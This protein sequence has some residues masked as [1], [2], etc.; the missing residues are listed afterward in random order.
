MKR[1]AMKGD[2]NHSNGVS[3][4]RTNIKWSGDMLWKWISKA[5]KSAGIKELKYVPM[6]SGWL[7]NT[8]VWGGFYTVKSG[9]TTAVLPFNVDK[10]GN[11]HLNVSPNKFIVGKVGKLPQV[12]KTLKDF[13]KTDLGIREGLKEMKKLFTIQNIKKAIAIAKK[14]KGNMTGA[15]KKIE[16]MNRG[17]SDEPDVAAALRLANESVK[18]D[19]KKEYKKYGS[20]TKSKKYR[21]ELNQYNRKKGTYGNGD[22]KDASHKGGK[23]VGFESQSKNRGR[24]EKSRLKKEGQ[25]RDYETAYTTFYNAYKNFA[26]ASMDVAKESTKISGE[27]TDQKIILKNFKKHVIPFIGLMSSWNKGHQ[28]NPHLDEGRKAIGDFHQIEF[29]IQQAIQGMRALQDKINDAPYNSKWGKISDMLYK[30]EVDFINMLSRSI[31]QM[32]NVA[33]DKILE[34]TDTFDYNDMVLE[35]IESNVMGDLRRW[36]KID[37]IMENQDAY[38]ILSKYNKIVDSLMNKCDKELKKLKDTL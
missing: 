14:M 32:R 18:R 11:V 33:K 26:N 12:V 34:S 16:K 2:G 24:A 30:K 6:K 31:P 5:L 36:R 27:K 1:S 9:K 13:K 29:G 4:D 38:K 3:V 22:G 35:K 21:A 37:N 23:I 17:L 8:Y 20:S 7:G 15:V 28:K 10:V 25:K 19:Y